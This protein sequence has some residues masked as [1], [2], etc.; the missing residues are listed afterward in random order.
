MCSIPSRDKRI[1]LFLKASRP[2]PHL[3]QR[4]RTSGAITPHYYMH[5]WSAQGQLYLWETF[6]CSVV[7]FVSL[8]VTAGLCSESFSVAVWLLLR[9]FSHMLIF[10]EETF[11]NKLLELSLVYLG[12][13]LTHEV[14]NDY[15][16]R[17]WLQRLVWWV[18]GYSFPF[19]KRVVIKKTVANCN[20]SVNASRWGSK[21][22]H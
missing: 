21:L 1:F 8:P 20:S 9:H 18:F 4:L 15:A 2:V 6:C 22:L 17:G 7:V 14:W 13:L 10:G 12:L 16:L 11:V 19:R 3:L 5:S